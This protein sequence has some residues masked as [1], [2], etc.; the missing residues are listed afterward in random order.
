MSSDSLRKLFPQLLR[1]GYVPIPNRDK[2]CYLPKWSTIYV[3]EAQAQLWTRQMRWPAIGLRVEPPLL[4]IDFDIPDR[5][6][7]NALE[8][9][10]PSV[11]FD[12][13]ERIG[14]APKTA[15]FMRLALDRDEEPF[16]RF[17]TRRY[18]SGTTAFAVEAFGGGGGGKQIGSF[19]PHS[20]D[21]AG[22]V[23]KT[24]Q[25]VGERSPANVPIDD[26]PEISRKD[27]I[28]FID[29]A[30]ALLAAWPGLKVD[31]LSKGG[32]KFFNHHEHD[33]DDSTVFRDADGCEYTLEELEAEAKARFELK[34][35]EMRVTGSFTGDASSSG[36]AR[37]KVWW[38]KKHGLSVVDFKTDITHHVL[39][40][41]DDPELDKLLCEIFKINSGEDK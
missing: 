3:D 15:F 4:V 28:A 32:E 24:Y 17:K 19:G 29:E 35:P 9:I 39:R 30:D 8:G 12:G 25:W 20:H 14:N 27:V 41:K 26:L 2:H 23:L 21:D 7:L 36:S 10:T 5:D 1:N 37:C 13:L 16:H 18:L 33:L 6:I 31:A 38:S 22:N 11:V 34:Q 40:A